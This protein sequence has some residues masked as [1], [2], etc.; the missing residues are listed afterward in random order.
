MAAIASA[1]GVSLPESADG[2]ASVTPWLALPE[3]LSAA[4]ADL[5][6]LLHN[7]VAGPGEAPVYRDE[8][9]DTWGLATLAIRRRRE[10]EAARKTSQVSPDLIA[11][12]NQHRSKDHDQTHVE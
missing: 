11:L 5:V 6:A 9:L 8:V 4:L 7:L 2:I 10:L 1:L 3:W 12:I